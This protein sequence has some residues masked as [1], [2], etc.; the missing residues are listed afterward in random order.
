MAMPDGLATYFAANVKTQPLTISMAPDPQG[1]ASSRSLVDRLTP[2]CLNFPNRQNGG[3][4]WKSFG[5]GNPSSSMILNCTKCFPV[6]NISGLTWAQAMDVLY[7]AWLN[8][9][10]T[11]SLSASTRAAKICASTQGENCRMHCSSLTARNLYQRS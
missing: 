6:I 4:S 8:K 1:G 3:S 9:T 10:G 5:A 7:A 2:F 11:S